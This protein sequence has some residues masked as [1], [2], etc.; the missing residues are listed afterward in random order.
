MRRPSVHCR[1]ANALPSRLP[2]RATLTPSVEGAVTAHPRLSHA[3]KHPCP[4]ARRKRHHR[5][6]RAL[7]QAA[8]RYRE[9]R[10]ARRRA[11]NRQGHR[12]SERSSRRHARR[13]PGC[14]RRGSLRRRPAHHDR[15]KRRPASSRNP[16]PATR[17]RSPARPRASHTFPSCGG[18]PGR[19]N[20]FP[21]HRHLR[22][23]RYRRRPRRLRGR[24]TRGP[25]RPAH[26]LRGESAQPSAAPASTSAAFP[27]RPF[28]NPRK[29]STRCKAPS[30]IT[31]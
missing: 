8:R 21:R 30:R 18:D 22:R 9:S 2:S 23:H 17:H 28:C 11:R 25:A 7:D 19:Q 26:R 24:H 3:R 6:H 27:A 4:H 29:T 31:A 1:T 5:H 15:R 10:R 16:Q 12:R 20:R 14:P 13:A